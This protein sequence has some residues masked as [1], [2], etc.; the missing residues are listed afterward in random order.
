MYSYLQPLL[1]GAPTFQQ[2]FLSSLTTVT[3]Q[4]GTR[5]PRLDDVQTL[6]KKLVRTDAALLGMQNKVKHIHNNDDDV[7][8]TGDEDNAQTRDD[9][10]QH[11]G[12]WACM[13]Q[14]LGIRA[15]RTQLLEMHMDW[16]LTRVARESAGHAYAGTHPSLAAATVGRVKRSTMVMH[17][18][19]HVLV[20]V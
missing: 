10:R 20:Q 5:W 18:A 14:D 12:D 4:A 3:A 15:C 2:V 13:L 8:C 16:S 9:G 1:D 17:V 11:G 7:Q 6:Q 19:S